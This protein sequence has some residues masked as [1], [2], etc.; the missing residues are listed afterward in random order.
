MLSKQHTRLLKAI[1]KNRIIRVEK[2]NPDIDYLQE[3]GFIGCTVC[4]HPNDYFLQPYITEKG[5]AQ[6]DTIARE[7]RRWRIPVILS[8]VSLI[9][10][11]TA[12]LKPFFFPLN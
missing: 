4:D 12:L 7:N 2:K 1:S 9:I 11:L 5:K 10:A 6:L 3:L 8:V